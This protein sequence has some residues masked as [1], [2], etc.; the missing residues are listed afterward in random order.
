MGNSISATGD[1]LLLPEHH[2]E[3]FGDDISVL[4]LEDCSGYVPCLKIQTAIEKFMK[5]Y[6][7]HRLSMD[8]PM[9]GFIAACKDFPDRNKQGWIEVMFND[10]DHFADCMIKKNLDKVF[11]KWVSY[12]EKF[13]IQNFSN[14]DVIKKKLE[15]IS[16]G[17]IIINLIVR[18]PVRMAGLESDYHYETEP[19]IRLMDVFL[20]VLQ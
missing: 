7:E 6:D 14:P 4:R 9:E 1:S 3:F 8:T 11:V 13:A 10:Y 2:K 16:P 19:N 5:F 20:I 17:M 18:K 15:N 12:S